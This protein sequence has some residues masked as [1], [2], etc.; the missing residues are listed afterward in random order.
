GP[1]TATLDGAA[2]ASGDSVNTNGAHTLVVTDAAGNTATV[3]FTINI[4]STPDTTLPVVVGVVNGHTYTSP[5]TITYSDDS[6]TAISTLNGVNFISNTTVS[7]NGSY[8]LIVSDPSWNKVT[9]NFAIDTS[10]T[11][12]TPPSGG[13]GGGGGS[14]YDPTVRAYNTPLTINAT[15]PGVLTYVFADGSKV[16]IEI[17]AGAISDVTTFNISQE[18]LALPRTPL[19]SYNAALI[20]GVYRLTAVDKNQRLLTTNFLKPLTV[21]FIMSGLS[22]S[23][24]AGVYK[25]KDEASEWSLRGDVTFSNAN[26][27]AS[28]TSSELLT[29]YAIFR[30][31]DL[32]TTMKYT[33]IAV[34]ET[35]GEVLGATYYPDGTLLRSP[36]K[37]VYLINNDG[38]KC[39]IRTLAE[40]RQKHNKQEI[41]DVSFDEINKY[42]AG[43]GKK[44]NEP[45]CDSKGGYG[46]G[47]LIRSNDHKV[48]II[49]SGKKKHI[50]NLK[51]LAKYYFGVK[52]NNVCSSVTD[53]YSDYDA[54]TVS[55]LAS[56]QDGMLI[57]DSQKNIYVIKDGRKYHINT[58]KEL[59]DKFFGI[60]IND[61]SDKILKDILDY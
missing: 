44:T 23:V 9:I 42:P 41:I 14:A 55:E 56:Y 10:V 7:A 22:N 12:P 32:P 13:G 43:C 57:R 4:T 50:K 31:K 26:N 49:K 59:A 37:R 27:S 52:I 11:P 61:V 46:D 47:A 16:V 28:F 60:K 24:D 29:R 18:A 51:D 40:L 15:Q 8:T 58:L 20:G 5:V 35:P 19:A 53:S 6:G 1:V 17:P 38:Q 48:Y 2:F 25:A 33:G 45:I 54:T 39:W 30:V 3:S 21:T 36:D 34:V